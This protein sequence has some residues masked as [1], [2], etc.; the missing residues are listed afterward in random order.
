MLDLQHLQPAVALS[1]DRFTFR[2]TARLLALP[3]F[4]VA[5]TFKVLCLGHLKHLHPPVPVRLYKLVRPGD[6]NHLDIKH[7]ARF[8]SV[9]RRITGDRR[10]VSS[11]GA[12]YEQAHVA[13]DDDPR[14]AYSEALPDESR[15]TRLAF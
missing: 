14:L 3:L 9:G 11:A 8:D 15:S 6:M 12:G 10:F 1:H 13:R 5:S 2:R 4:T 7:L